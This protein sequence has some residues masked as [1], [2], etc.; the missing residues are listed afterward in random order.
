MSNRELGRVQARSRWLCA[1]VTGLVS[2]LTLVLAFSL[3]GAAAAPPGALGG[4]DLPRR[5]T[6]WFVHWAPALFYLWALV[7]VRRALGDIATGR[8]FTPALARALREVGLALGAGGATSAFVQP[9]LM[10]LMQDAGWGRQVFASYAHFDVA[11]AAVGAVGLALVLLSHVLTR[12][13]EIQA[14]LDEIF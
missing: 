12:A 11:Y 3:F 5:L 2:L 6:T 7:A 4:A 13:A 10:R 1:A 8:F 14:E 9:N